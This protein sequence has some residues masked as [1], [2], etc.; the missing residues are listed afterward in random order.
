MSEALPATANARVAPRAK[1][2][3]TTPS[4]FGVSSSL[5]V[6]AGT[7]DAQTPKRAPARTN[8]AAAARRGVRTLGKEDRQGIGAMGALLLTTALLRGYAVTART[9]MAALCRVD[10]RPGNAHRRRKCGR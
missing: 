3:S 2:K 8:S 1:S 10:I 7:R 4:S 6:T 5:A 9:P